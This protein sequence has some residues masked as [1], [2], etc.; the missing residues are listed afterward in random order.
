MQ[1]WHC[2]L[3]NKQTTKQINQSVSLLTVP[4][5]PEVLAERLISIS[6]QQL[7]QSPPRLPQ[8]CHFPSSWLSQ[9]RGVEPQGWHCREMEDEGCQSHRGGENLAD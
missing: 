9:N 2:Q 3:L 6:P 4:L 1:G 7:Q 5:C 8:P